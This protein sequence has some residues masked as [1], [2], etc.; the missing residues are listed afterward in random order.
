[1]TKQQKIVRTQTARSSAQI[2]GA[3]RLRWGSVLFA[4]LLVVAGIVV[5]QWPGQV[6]A[7]PLTGGIPTPIGFPDAAQ[8]VATL[9][10]QPAPAFRLPDETGASIAVEP[11]A[12]E[13]LIVLIFNMGLG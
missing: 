6:E 7:P 8:D 9:V 13:K 5:W 3:S 4:L 1:M 11:G 12:D 10:G 2:A